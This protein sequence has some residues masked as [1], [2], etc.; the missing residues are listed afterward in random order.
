V[1]A[2][3]S[4]RVLN[5]PGPTGLGKTEDEA[6][7]A[8]IDSL[9]AI[10]IYRLKTGQSMP[11]PGAKVPIEFASAT[12]V[13]ADTALL[14]DFIEQVLGFGPDEGVFISD[15]SSIGDFGDDDEVAR[16]KARIEQLYGMAITESG[17]ILV[18]DIL[19]RVRA[20]REDYP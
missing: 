10:S 16:I 7:S 20:L 19:E 8:L 13:N 15:L 6:R 12:R 3:W 4:A 5:W 11:R 1:E 14:D 2:K 17:P 9:H 18:A